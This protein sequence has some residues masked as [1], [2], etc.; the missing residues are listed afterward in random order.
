[1]RLRGWGL[2]GTAQQAP[3]GVAMSKLSATGNLTAIFSRVALFSLV[4][5]GAG[6]GLATATA[7]AAED[8]IT[9]EQ[10]VR[11]LAPAKMP[12]TRSL[13]AAPQRSVSANASEGQFVQT[14]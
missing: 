9:E 10:I 14:I 2:I 4:A 8:T 7:L 1:L 12:L 5:L 3:G 6:L 11:A 13:S